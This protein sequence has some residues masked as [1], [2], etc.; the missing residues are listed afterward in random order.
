MAYQNVL[1]APSTDAA[2]ALAV[3]AGKGLVWSVPV[4]GAEVLAEDAR[5][6]CVTIADEHVQAFDQAMPG[7]KRDKAGPWV[8][9]ASGSVMP[10]QLAPL[11]A[12]RNAWAA[13]AVA[14]AL[15]Q[16]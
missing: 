10:D 6:V 16:V 7:S 8:S 15:V 13:K 4:L 9:L 5:R 12:A 1:L 3:T 11:D 14:V 2:A